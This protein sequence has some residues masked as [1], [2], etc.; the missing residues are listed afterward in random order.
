MGDVVNPAVNVV[1]IINDILKGV[2]LE[3]AYAA[4]VAAFPFLGW[5]VIGWIL[6][7]VISKVGGAIFAVLEKLTSFTVI[8]W[9]T[10]AQQAAYDNAVAALKQA[11]ASGDPN[12]L[13]IARTSFKNTLRD[14]VHLDG[15]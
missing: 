13:Q 6:H 1:D 4:L 5:P 2:S 8:N 7:W 15:D 14:L 10:D 11:H 3:G 12:A 9:Q